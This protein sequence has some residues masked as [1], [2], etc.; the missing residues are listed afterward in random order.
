MQDVGTLEYN[1]IR[2]LNAENYF[3]VGDDYQAIYGFKG[4]NVNIFKGLVNDPS[5]DTYMLTNNYRNGTDILA[6]ADIIIRQVDDRIQKEITPI[7]EETGEVTIMSKANLSV[8]LDDL[9]YHDNLKD[10]FLLVRS[11]KEL[12]EMTNKCSALGLPFITFKREGMSL[13]ELKRKMNKN[14]LKILTVHT[15]KGLE[16]DNV[17]LYGNFPV[18]VPFYR[19]NKEERR[20]M[21]VGITRARKSLTILN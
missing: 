5:F 19:V 11:N 18:E 8:V 13:S 4:G 15:S 6:L 1:F 9:L 17:I 2:S 3:F 7:K 12:F 14:A 21:Y 20:V 10:Y 16:V